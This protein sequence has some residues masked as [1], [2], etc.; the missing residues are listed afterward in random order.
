MKSSHNLTYQELQVPES[1]SKG[2]C[3]KRKNNREAILLAKA[4]ASIHG[5]CEKKG[6]DKAAWHHH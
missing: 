3:H 6:D 1:V 2:V 5:T 4:G